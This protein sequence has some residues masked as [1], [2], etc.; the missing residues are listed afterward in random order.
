MSFYPSLFEVPKWNWSSLL[1]GIDHRWCA[2]VGENKAVLIAQ[3]LRPDIVSKWKQQ[4]GW[5]DILDSSQKNKSMFSCGSSRRITSLK[6]PGLNTSHHFSF[7]PRRLVIFWRLLS[8]RIDQDFVNKNMNL[9]GHCSKQWQVLL[10]LRTLEEPELVGPVRITAPHHADSFILPF[11]TVSSCHHWLQSTGSLLL[12]L[13][14]MQ[15]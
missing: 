5:S 12:I 9:L 11:T 6:P 10:G 14:G 3:K 8:Q 15:T 1:L 4:P 7:C 2:L 13:N